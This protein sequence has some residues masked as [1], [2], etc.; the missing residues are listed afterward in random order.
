[1]HRCLLLVTIVASLAAAAGCSA[2]GGRH[3][4][5]PGASVADHSTTNDPSWT[6]PGEM[7]V[8]YGEGRADVMRRTPKGS[9]QIKPNAA[10]KP[11]HGAVHAAVY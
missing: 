11:M 6:P 4:A 3:A 5:V 1:M 7:E 9:E 10:Q 8:S 2:R